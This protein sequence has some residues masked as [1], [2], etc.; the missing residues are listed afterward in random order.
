[1]KIL[2]VLFLFIILL[3]IKLNSLIVLNTLDL[4]EMLD[5]LDL[6]KNEFYS[7]L[8]SNFGGKMLLDIGII[9]IFIY[10][11]YLSIDM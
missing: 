11:I 8:K 2:Y 6:N 7:D 1:M 3:K 5:A 4:D 10:I 9:S